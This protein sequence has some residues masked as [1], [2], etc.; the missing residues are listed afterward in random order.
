MYLTNRICLKICHVSTEYKISINK[1]LY[2]LGDTKLETAL[3][4]CLHL[5]VHFM[6][7]VQGTHDNEAQKF[8]I[9]STL[10]WL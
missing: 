2:I 6:N 4:H 7:L 8:S 5:Q 3:R 10:L 1:H 9:Q